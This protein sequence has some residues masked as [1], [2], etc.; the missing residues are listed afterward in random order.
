MADAA[1]AAAAASADVA[2]AA[3]DDDYCPQPPAPY[4]VLSLAGTTVLLTGASAGIG[5]ALAW[6]LAAE[7]CRLVLVARRL[8]RLDRLAAA[9][10]ARHPALEVATAAADLSDPRQ[11]EA[12][13]PDGLPAG[14][15]EIDIL[16]NNAGLALGVASVAENDLGDARTVLETN[17]ASVVALTR[18]SARG[19]LARAPRPGHLVFLSSVAGHE[20]YAGG[21]VYCASKAAVEAFAASARHD[22]VAS[23]V[24][25]ATVSPGAVNTDFSTTRFGGDRTKA[26]AV[27]AGFDPLVA[28]DVADQ[29][30]WCLTR[31]LRVQV[32]DVRVL[33]GSQCSAKGIHRRE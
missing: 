33:A 1:A 5:E 16:I 17:V 20:P 11:A 7:G 21:S 4:D 24:R 28:A 29:V 9:L 26:D 2:A 32:T 30:C 14:F 27:Y 23:A 19:M 22:L 12:L 8:A 13:V 15:R 3:A 10:R 31:P 25:V 18:S 6:R